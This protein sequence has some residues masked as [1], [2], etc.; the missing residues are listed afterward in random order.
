MA[1]YQLLRDHLMYTN[2]EIYKCISVKSY[3][4]SECEA[5]MLNEINIQFCNQLYGKSLFEAGKDYIVRLDDVRDLYTFL[6][7]CSKKIKSRVRNERCGFIKINKVSILPYCKV[8]G[9]TKYVPILFLDGPTDNLKHRSI[10]LENWDLAYLKF[11]CIVMGID[12]N[13][14]FE[15]YSCEVI[16]LIYVKQQFPRWSRFIDYWPLIVANLQPLKNLKGELVP[17]KHS[18]GVWIKPPIE[19]SEQ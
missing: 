3:F 18:S 1:E 8:N 5:K 11:T 9:N 6:E 17:I 14:Y 7:F 19:T 4:I 12:T 2:P 10:K 16:S 15:K 13:L